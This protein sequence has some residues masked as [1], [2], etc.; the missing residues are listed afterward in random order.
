MSLSR[1]D[2]DGM[3]RFRLFGGLISGEVRGERGV[4]GASSE[5]EPA[6]LT[7]VAVSSETENVEV[8]EDA[9]ELLG[10]SGNLSNE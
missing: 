5:P 10:L 8:G 1:I 4:R 6:R 3:R 9:E 2:G 7:I